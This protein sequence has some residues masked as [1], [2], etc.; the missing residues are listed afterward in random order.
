MIR[1][2]RSYSGEVSSVPFELIELVVDLFGVALELWSE[3]WDKRNN[4][5]A[6]LRP[7][8]DEQ[9][10]GKTKTLFDGLKQQIKM[11]P[12]IFRLM[13]HAPAVLEHTLGLNEAIQTGL[14]PK[15]RELAYLKASQVLHCGYC[16]HYH[17]I[18][19]KRAGL[20]DAQLRE[21]EG[22]ESSTAFSDLEKQVLRFAEQW[23]TK[24]KA[25]AD[26]VSK[27]SQQLSPQ[28]M[29]TLAAT[30]GLANWTSRFNV[31]FGVELP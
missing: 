13:G 6:T 12:N 21:V 10:Q 2:A 22:Y 30:V 19:G 17:Q 29:M 14:D 3:S 26:L 5:M 4:P 15:L 9:A 28:E 11:V 25:D 24:G 16:H 23:T 7:L 31:T 8:S 20:T 18:F 1:A 27:L